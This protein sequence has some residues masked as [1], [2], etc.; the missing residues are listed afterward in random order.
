M[1]DFLFHQS[2]ILTRHLYTFTHRLLF[3]TLEH[4]L[5]DNFNFR[6]VECNIDNIIF[7]NTD[8]FPQKT[9][10]TKNLTGITR[11]GS[12]KDD[13]LW[14]D[15]ILSVFGETTL[16]KCLWLQPTFS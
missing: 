12:Q 5:H 6:F 16:S 9:E 8:S 11:D 4:Y 14:A 7:I 10:I 3:C 1:V 2:N 15:S 13:M